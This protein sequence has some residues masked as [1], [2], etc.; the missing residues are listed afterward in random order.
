MV[1]WSA[2][3]PVVL[4]F[5][6]SKHSDFLLTKISSLSRCFWIFEIVCPLCDSET[7]RLL[8]TKLI[9]PI[10]YHLDRLAHSGRGRKMHA[11][12]NACIRESAS[13]PRIRRCTRPAGR[14]PRGRRGRP[15]Y[16]PRIHRRAYADWTLLRRGYV[17]AAVYLSAGLYCTATYRSTILEE[18]RLHDIV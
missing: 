2:T 15:A 9:R 1:R 13:G 6:S 14:G 3:D 10:L 5:L 18:V 17:A 12:A 4:Y 8:V 7:T 11:I 16:Y